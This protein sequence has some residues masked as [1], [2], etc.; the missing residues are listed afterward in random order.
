MNLSDLQS[1]GAFA[2]TKLAKREVKFKRPIQRPA[3]NWAD[4]DVPEFTGEMADESMTVYIRPATS[5]DLIEV[6]R[7]DDR[8]RPFVALMRALCNADGSPLLPDLDT[9]MRLQPWLAL[10]LLEAS[11][12]ARGALPNASAPKTSSGANSPSPSG[13]EAS[14]SGRTE[15]RSTKNR[16]GVST[17]PS[18]AP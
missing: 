4:A 14:A 17:E 12:E 5:A 2:S 18:A 6:A 1:M 16:S 9:A 10:P 13:D 7:A 8:S 11:N 3:E 15:S